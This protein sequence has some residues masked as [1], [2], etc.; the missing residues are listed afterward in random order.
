ME[1]VL[2]ST[3]SHSSLFA[4]FDIIFASFCI[5]FVQKT[6]RDIDR[7]SFAVVFNVL[8]LC[9]VLAIMRGN[10]S[11]SVTMMLHAPS[12]TSYSF[13]TKYLDVVQEK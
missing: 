13:I 12:F 8:L 2:G 1:E 4:L 3:P 5:I 7:A 10:G 11:Y 9:N 6:R